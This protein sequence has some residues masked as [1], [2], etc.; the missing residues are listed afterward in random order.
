[1]SFLSVGTYSKLHF[2]GSFEFLFL[3]EN[4]FHVVETVI[5]ITLKGEEHV[6]GYILFGPNVYHEL[7]YKILSWFSPL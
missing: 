7:G 3:L 6:K 2:Y 1:M 4:L 5:I